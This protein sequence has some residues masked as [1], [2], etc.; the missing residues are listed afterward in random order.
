MAEVY[1]NIGRLFHLLGI[2]YLALKYYE[3]A[4]KEAEKDGSNSDIK[5]LISM[6][7]IIALMSVKN[8]QAAY[9]LLKSR[10]VL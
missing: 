7:N 1:Y 5:N 10:M 9:R 4:M 6:N 2:N 3:D 8:K